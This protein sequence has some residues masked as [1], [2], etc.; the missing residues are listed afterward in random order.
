MIDS[1]LVFQTNFPMDNGDE[2][3][4]MFVPPP[5]PPT[6]STVPQSMGG[7]ATFIVPHIHPGSRG[8]PPPGFTYATLRPGQRAMGGHGMGEVTF[9]EFV[10]PPPPMFESG[11]PAVLTRPAGATNG[12]EP[13]KKGTGKKQE[14]CV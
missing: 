7:N 9:H 14:S 11:A 13:K 5:P 8:P 4:H 1:I 2:H 10:P 6:S 12:E 3:Q